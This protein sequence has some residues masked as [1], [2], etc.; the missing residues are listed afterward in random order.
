MIEALGRWP[1]VNVKTHSLALRGNLKTLLEGNGRE[2]WMEI[3][4]LKYAPSSYALLD[5]S[6][7]ASLKNL[8]ILHLTTGL[9]LPLHP[10]LSF[11][12]L[13]HLIL[14]RDVLTRTE[15]LFNENFFPALRHLSL[16]EVRP[17]RPLD[18]LLGPLLSQLTSLAVYEP[19]AS[20]LERV[21][22]KLENCR[23][24]ALNCR[25]QD[26][27]QIV[28][29][30]PEDQGALAGLEDLHLESNGRTADDLRELFSMTRCCGGG[31]WGLEAKRIV[32][33]GPRN[34]P[35]REEDESDN[36]FEWR[37]TKIRFD[38]FDGR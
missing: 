21:L 30:N 11:P 7:L 8:R 1:F 16:I 14:G 13:S 27:E 32:L 9:I 38:E 15:T 25:I 35:E 12:H 26:L 37:N 31:G 3:Q 18:R 28:R 20:S 22:C 2:R 29:F 6:L 4:A 19:H 10:A 36:R 5:L 24:L 23:H 17:R 33:Y 34:C